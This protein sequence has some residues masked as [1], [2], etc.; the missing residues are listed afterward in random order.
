MREL[1]RGFMRKG[2]SPGRGRTLT[3]EP[4]PSGEKDESGVKVDDCT[5]T[6]KRAHSGLELGEKKQRGG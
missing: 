2:S 5:G 6:V 1:L 4:A 3:G